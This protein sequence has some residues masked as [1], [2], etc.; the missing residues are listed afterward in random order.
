MAM[1][2]RMQAELEFEVFMTVLQGIVN[3]ELSKKL[4]TLFKKRIYSIM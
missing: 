2:Y 3:T 4:F 1:F